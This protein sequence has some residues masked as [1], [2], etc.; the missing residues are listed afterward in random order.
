[1]LLTT[2][3]EPFLGLIAILFFL[4]LI[5]WRLSIFKQFLTPL[6]EEAAEYSNLMR[7]FNVK[8]TD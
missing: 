3:I 4:L 8:E 6:G 5:K 1:M 2:F 7:L